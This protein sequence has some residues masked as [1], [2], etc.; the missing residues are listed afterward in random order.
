LGDP[1]VNCAETQ[2]KGAAYKDEAGDGRDFTAQ[3]DRRIRIDG[4]E[5][6]G[7]AEGIR[8]A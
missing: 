1:R 4:D 6:R 2:S 5:F 7:A 3:R 8:A